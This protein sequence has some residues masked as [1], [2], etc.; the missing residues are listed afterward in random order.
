M[1]SSTQCTAAINDTVSA[2]LARVLDCIQ[3]SRLGL[4]PRRDEEPG[5]KR[6]LLIHLRLVPSYPHHGDHASAIVNEA[7]GQAT[8]QAVR[9][10]T[11]LSCPLGNGKG[12]GDRARARA[13]ACALATVTG[14]RPLR[15]DVVPKRRCSPDKG[16]CHPDM[17]RRCLACI[18]GTPVAE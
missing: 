16:L 18:A 15:S 6:K 2:I 14:L 4:R 1:H 7:N 9:R 3:V 8:M 12:D 11:S 17:C 13:M 10:S 5:I